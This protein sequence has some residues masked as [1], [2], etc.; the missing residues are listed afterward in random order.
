MVNVAFDRDDWTLTASPNSA[1]LNN[2][3]DSN[4][5]TRWT[6]RAFQS[7]GQWLTIDLGSP[8]VFNQIVLGTQQSPE[9][10]PRIY[11]LYVSSDGNDWGSALKTEEGTE[12]VTEIDFTTA[13]AQYIRIA[14]LG[15]STNRW[16]SVHE[17]NIYL[18]DNPTQPT[19]EPSP[20]PIVDECN[21]T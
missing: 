18:R 19:P 4:A 3:I 6:T 9:D 2:A 10:H 11:E 13:T 15:S 5:N 1:E 14:Q 16:W 12:S 8:K 20:Q 21:T 7:P 17:L